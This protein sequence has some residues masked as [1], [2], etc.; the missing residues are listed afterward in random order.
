[1]C[2]VFIWEQTA[3]WTTY[4]INWLVFITEI[5]SVY[6]AVRTGSLNKAVFSS[7]LKGYSNAKPGGRNIKYSWNAVSTIRKIKY[8][9]LERSFWRKGNRAN[10]HGHLNNSC[11]TERVPITATVTSFRNTGDVRRN[12]LI[13]NKWMFVFFQSVSDFANDCVWTSHRT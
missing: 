5:K 7:S 9:L 8:F 13:L 4:S 6:S 1:M 2:F 10:F 3:T 12:D 11:T